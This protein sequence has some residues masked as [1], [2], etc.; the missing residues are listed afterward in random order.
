[1]NRI[2]KRGQIFTWDFIFATGIFL[3]ILAGIVYLWD[4]TIYEIDSSEKNYE[5]NWILGTVAGQ[6]IGTPGIPEDWW[7]N[8]DDVRVLGLV[9]AEGYM[10]YSR[11]LDI[12]KLLHFSNMS[13]NYSVLRNRLLGTGEYEFYAEFSCLNSSNRDCFSGIYVDSIEKGNITCSNGFNFTIHNHCT[14]V[15]LW[16]EA[17]KYDALIGNPDQQLDLSMSNGS[18]M[19]MTTDGRGMIYNVT[20]PTGIYDLWIRYDKEGGPNVDMKISIDDLEFIKTYTGDT[21]LGWNKTIQNIQ[22]NEGS[23]TVIIERKTAAGAPF[24]FDVFLLTTDFDYVPSTVLPVCKSFGCEK[25]LTGCIIGNYLA[26]NSTMM[27]SDTK[28]A[29]FSDNLDRTIRLKLVVWN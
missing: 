26:E 6:L 11:I 28:T 23:H 4:S 5:I 21:P 17:E 12:D 15:Y 7:K 13:K 22:L 29:T 14:D 10:S 20:L 2:N 18:H 24:D 1:M 16:R 3:V 27:V 8:P 19:Q 9:D 25:V